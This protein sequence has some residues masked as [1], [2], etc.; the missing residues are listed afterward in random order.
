VIALIDNKLEEDKIRMNK[1][2][3]NNLRVNLGDVVEIKRGGEIGNLTKIH[4][5]PLSDTIKGI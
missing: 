1:T 4:V 2:V 3:R 5:A